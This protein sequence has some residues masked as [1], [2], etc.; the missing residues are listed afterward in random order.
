MNIRVFRSAVVMALVAV[1]VACGGA[2][3][4]KA[5]YLE[6]GK[7]YFAEDNYDK[8]EI[9][10]KNVLQIDP[11]TAEPYY[12]LGK[13]AESDQEWARAFG[14]YS[15]AV[16]LD[17]NLIRPRARLA[18]F[19]LLQANAEKVNGD[20]D[21]E[22]TAL[23]RA[24]AELEEVLKRAPDDVEAVTIQAAITQRGGD[25][26]AAITRLEQIVARAPDHNPAVVLLASLYE[27]NQDVDKAGATLEAGV[28]AKPDDVG[29]KM[30][31]AQFYNR[32]K[33]EDDATQV[34]RDVVAQKPEEFGYRLTLARFLTDRK[35]AD[36]AET[37]LREA[38]AADPDDARRYVALAEFLSA[39]QG[40][41]VAIKDLEQAIS[42][43]PD[44]V[45]L[46]FSLARLYQTSGEVDNSMKVLQR[47]VDEQDTEPAGLRAR[48][49]LAQIYASQSDFDKARVLVEEVLKENPKDND[50]LTLKGRLAV[51]AGDF[52]EAIAVFRSVLKDQ[53]NSVAVLSYLAETQ[54]RNG[55]VELAGENLRRAVDVEPQNAEARIRLARYLMQTKDFA[56]GLEQVDAVLAKTPD[57][58][59]AL[60]VKSNIL[61]AKGDQAGVGPVLESLK[62]TQDGRVEG[63][64]RS[65]RLHLLQKDA[66]AALQDVEVV[67]AEQPD[68]LAALTAKSDALAALGDQAA[69]ES[70]LVKMKEV[71]PEE[72]GSY[73]RMGRFYR[74]QQK[75]DEAIREYETGLGY[76][77]AQAKVQ[78][79]T[80]IVNTEL[81]LGKTDAAKARLNA[82]LEKEPDNPVANDLLGAIYLQEKK[83]P[84]A[85]TAF[86]K[87][88]EINPKSAIVYN[89]LAAA[90][91]GQDNPAGAV[92]AYEDGLKILP[93]DPQL[94]LGL[95]GMH[96]RQKDYDQALKVYEQVLTSNPDNLIAINNVA[97]L[98]ADHKQDAANLKR[99]KELASR[100]ADAEQPALRDTLGWVNYR[101]GDYDAAVPLLRGVVDKA[102]KV[103][104]FQ[105]H[106]GMAL[107]KQGDKAGAKTHLG[108]AIEL[109][110]FE[111]SAEAKQTLEGIK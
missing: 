60:V 76:A 21:A 37:V 79:L 11:K 7:A 96:E 71:A 68:N 23:A 73:F 10:F 74:A 97:A 49:L 85:E 32:Q 87:Q 15:K 34:L 39:Q 25:N 59:T 107:Y 65:A 43:K 42:S 9:E 78:L 86:A 54:L 111:G 75:Y 35:E 47:V 99:A 108:K 57:D 22:Q 110:E 8:A 67:L 18:Q 20:A 93:D 27:Q 3:E 40:N 24:A 19:Y 2:E 105:Y 82:I 63:Y 100:L 80:E 62:E 83:Y 66:S 29:L 6:R 69:L 61:A 46:R 55:D 44:L 17:E 38:I 16:E 36:A 12:Y 109:G 56:G 13:I 53:P 92:T 103:A 98:L 26:E 1:L 77:T 102:P 50:A 101:L 30:A 72:A 48:N 4:R 64:L 58:V 89:Q 28:K 104:I 95:A 90:R 51:N 106:L 31:L 84:E 81:A 52:P 45:E 70:V 94:L 33:R 14:M 41:D 5:K 88:L 91:I